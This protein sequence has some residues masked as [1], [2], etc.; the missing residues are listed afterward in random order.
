MVLNASEDSQVGGAILS[1]NVNVLVTFEP[2]QV[3]WHHPLS[4]VSSF[5]HYLRSIFVFLLFKFNFVF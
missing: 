5:S 4:N 3:L 1:G 2:D